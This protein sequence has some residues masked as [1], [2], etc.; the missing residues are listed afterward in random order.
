M[1]ANTGFFLSIIGIV[2]QIALFI[3]YFLC[4]KPV[5]IGVS[6]PPKKP[7]ILITDW[8]KDIKKKNKTE[9]EVYI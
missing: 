4:S 5:I 2:A 9:N 7:L 6:N 1:K 8:V 3:Y